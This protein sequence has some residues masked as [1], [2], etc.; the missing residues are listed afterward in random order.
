[1]HMLKKVLLLLCV[2]T[3]GGGTGAPAQDDDSFIDGFPDVPYMDIIERID[4]EPM[5]FD[6]ASGTVAEAT[7][8]FSVTANQATKEY[9]A[10]LNGLGWACEQ[11]Q[12]ELSCMRE[13][14]VVSFIA[15]TSS[16]NSSS[17]ILRLEPRR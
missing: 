16:Q 2:L 14:T 13:N 9:Q 6:T 10:A 4:G 7:I 12:R 5:I 17:F 3:A 8:F 1:M 11:T 15:Q